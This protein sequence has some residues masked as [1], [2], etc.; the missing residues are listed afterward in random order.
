MI[1]RLVNKIKS[2]FRGKPE[3][4]VSVYDGSVKKKNISIERRYVEGDFNNHYYCDE[5]DFLEE[6][7]NL[8]FKRVKDN[9]TKINVF[10]FNDAFYFHKHGR[11]ILLQKNKVLKELSF[12]GYYEPRQEIVLSIPYFPKKRR[13]KGKVLCLCTTGAESNYYTF[14]LKLIQRIG[15]AL[16]AGFQLSDF[17]FILIND[18]N[19]KFQNELLEMHGVSKSKVISVREGDFFSFDDL[20]VPEVG[21]Q[22][23]I[24]F[25]YL[26]EKYQINNLVSPKRRIYASR[27]RAKWMKIVDEKFLIPILEKYNVDIIFLENYSVAEQI[28]LFKDT[29]L[30]ITPHGAGLAN[31]VFMKEGSLVIEIMNRNRIHVGYHAY[32]VLN[33]LK[34]AYVRVDS[35]DNEFSNGKESTKNLCFKS[36]DAVKLEAAL[37]WYLKK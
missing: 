3:E 7:D 21:L 1:S 13:I 11:C 22:S 33:N 31:V 29:E 32:S 27:S 6:V 36:E 28:E 10:T 26:R 2:I 12:D 24:G 25:D 37:N 4:I 34:Y 14:H 5:S 15:F 9:C 23:L 30:L 18:S 35:V 8:S 16:K 17:D 19:K 20:I